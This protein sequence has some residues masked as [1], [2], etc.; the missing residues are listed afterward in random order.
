ML[1]KY[2]QNVTF[3]RNGTLMVLLNQVVLLNRNGAFKMVL[4]VIK[5]DLF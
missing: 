4:S 5:K 3:N 2:K 1:G